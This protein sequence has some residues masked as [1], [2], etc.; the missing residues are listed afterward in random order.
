MTIDQKL[1]EVLRTEMRAGVNDM[2]TEL[3]AGVSELRTE[4]QAGA[5][6]L[7]AGINLLADKIDQT[8]A[9]LADFRQEVSIKF[10]GVTALFLA[11]E[12]NVSRLEDRVLRL[13]DRLDTI[14]K[15][16]NSA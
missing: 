1:I 5:N 11:S 9:T 4:I 6:D 2:R 14:E 8:N 3:Q 10:D 16:Q 15:R 12:H 7:R 13:E